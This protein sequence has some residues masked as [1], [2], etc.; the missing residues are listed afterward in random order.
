VFECQYDT[1][2]DGDCHRCARRG[3]C[4]ERP[5]E[6]RIVK[7]ML[8]DLWGRAGF[9]DF[10]GEIQVDVQREIQGTLEDKV[11]KLLETV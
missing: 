10:W 6:S 4:L 8:E 7:T 11:R 5:L 3:G 2:S 9:D 1:D